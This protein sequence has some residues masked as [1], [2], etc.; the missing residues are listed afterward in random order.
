MISY[1]FGVSKQDVIISLDFN[2]KLVKG[3]TLLQL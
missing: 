1:S 2:Q 3:E